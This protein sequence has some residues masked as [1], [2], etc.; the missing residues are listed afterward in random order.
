MAAVA[1]QIRG[2]LYDLLSRTS[3]QVLLQGEASLL[4]LGIGG[5]PVLPPESGGGPVDPGYGYPERP[6]DPGWGVPERPPHIWGPTDPRP[7][8]PIVI[9]PNVP[10]G[11]QPPEAPS[12]GDPTTP[13]PPPQGTGGGPVQPVTPPPY[14][15]VN[16]P[17]VGPVYVAPPL[18][19][20]PKG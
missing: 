19:A 16:Y 2:T 8:P 14:I 1:I 18:T 3:R 11:M 9:P 20:Q 15:I 10:P 6:V 13:V 12:P 5:G 17:G 4:G 7:T